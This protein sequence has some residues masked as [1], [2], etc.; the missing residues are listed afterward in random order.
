LTLIHPASP[1]CRATRYKCQHYTLL[2]VIKSS[3]TT[4]K[5]ESIQKSKTKSFVVLLLS[6][7]NHD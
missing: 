1:M 4:F 2:T 6:N 7:S 5:A 3:K